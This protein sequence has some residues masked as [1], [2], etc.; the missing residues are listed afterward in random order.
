MTHTLKSTIDS[1]YYSSES[2]TLRILSVE[3]SAANTTSVTRTLSTKLLHQLGEQ[4]ANIE[5]KRRD[6]AKGLPFINEAWI[7]ANFTPSTERNN[8]QQASLALSDTLVAELQAANVVVIGVPMY[9]FGVPASLKAWIDLVARAGLT[10][11]YTE[12]GPV[13]LLNNKKA[14]VIVASGGTPLGGNMDFVTGYL[15][16]ILGFIGIHDV[17]IIQAERLNINAAQQLEQAHNQIK[18][19]VTALSTVVM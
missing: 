8:Q 1:K 7:G 16:H 3:S 6:V 13:G 15:R 10:F 11:R 17:E 2:E 14:Y 5:I 18:K 19:A 9:N 4:Y 12:Q